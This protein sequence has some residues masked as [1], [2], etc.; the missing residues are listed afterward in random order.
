MFC[1]EKP[2]TGVFVRTGNHGFRR[3]FGKLLVED[4]V[5]G[6]YALQLGFV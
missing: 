4:P 2:A 3:V 5:A 1:S 6:F